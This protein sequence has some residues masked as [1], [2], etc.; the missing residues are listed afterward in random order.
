[1]IKRLRAALTPA[2]AMLLLALFLCAAIVSSWS[3][4]GQSDLEARASRILSEVAGAGKVSVVIATRRPGGREAVLGAQGGETQAIPSGAVAV[5]QG[6]DDPFVCAQL[7]QA[8][9]AL[10]GLPASSV[11]VISGGE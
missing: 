9:C 4:G 3:G 10:L 1:M 11:S 8:L 6:A 5:A 7:T 2:A